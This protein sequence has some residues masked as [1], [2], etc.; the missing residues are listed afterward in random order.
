MTKVNLTDPSRNLTEE[1]KDLLRWYQ[2]HIPPWAQPYWIP[3]IQEGDTVAAQLLF[4]AIDPKIRAF[5]LTE[6]SCHQEPNNYLVTPAVFRELLATTWMHSHHALFN[7]IRTRRMEYNGSPQCLDEWMDFELSIRDEVVELFRLA[8]FPPCGEQEGMITV[9]RGTFGLPVEA[10]RQG[11]S[12]S[13]SR[14]KA[15]WFAMRGLAGSTDIYPRYEFNHEYG[16]KILK[17]TISRKDVLLWSN[18]RSEQEVVAVV[19]GTV[20]AEEAEE[21]WVLFDSLEEMSAAQED[22]LVIDRKLAPDRL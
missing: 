21:Q 12:W 5:L 1:E 6:I 11:L 9:Y 8:A 18:S 4:R 17:A 10:G 19:D 15:N 3:A 2:S 22:P 20:E 13:L 7:L 14:S 16:A